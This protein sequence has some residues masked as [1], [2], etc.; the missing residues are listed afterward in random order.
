M[1]F[2]NYVLFNLLVAILVEGFS[3]EVC[4]YAPNY[5]PPVS[6]VL[7]TSL[8][9]LIALNFKNKTKIDVNLKNSAHFRI[10]NINVHIW[11]SAWRA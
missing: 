10:N 3:A 4:N 5:L 2:G 1:T 8:Y 7:A 6:L 11:H 9:H